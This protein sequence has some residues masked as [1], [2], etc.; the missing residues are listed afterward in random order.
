M[1]KLLLVASKLATRGGKLMLS[2]EAGNHCCCGA[3]CACCTRGIRGV[4]VTLGGYG[5][6]YPGDDCEYDCASRNGDYWVPANALV[7]CQSDLEP[8]IT[9]SDLCPGG[10]VD[11]SF[12]I[13]WAITCGTDV[14][15][16]YVALQVVVFDGVST[17]FYKR[18]P[19]ALEGP[20]DCA[21]L[22]SGDVPKSFAGAT[23]AN[24]DDTDATVSAEVLT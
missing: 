20:V 1:A 6:V 2:N 17:S 11:H 7:V 13:Q 8:F 21:A 23:G 9:G 14:D 5:A 3:P 4:V 10:T 16:P 19:L 24:C 12:G 15:G 22:L 18:V